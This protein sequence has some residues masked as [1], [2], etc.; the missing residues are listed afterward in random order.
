M[1]ANTWIP[2]TVALQGQ[3]DGNDPQ[4]E[5]PLNATLLAERAAAAGVAVLIIIGFV[6]SYTTVRD[7]AVEVGDFPAW[8]A[9]VVPLSFD[10]GIIVLSLRILLAAGDGRPARVLRALVL[11]LSV[12][13]VVVNGVASD[14][15]AGRLLHA[16]PSAM[17]VICFETV[18]VS[19]QHRALGAE[20]TPPDTRFRTARWLLA[21]RS[22]WTTWRAHVLTDGNAGSSQAAR[23]ATAPASLGES[24]RPEVAQPQRPRRAPRPST[25][26]R[27]PPPRGRADDRL[28]AARDVL[29]RNPDLSA[30]ALA[31]RLTDLGYPVSTRTAQRIRDTARRYLQAASPENPGPTGASGNA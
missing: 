2:P 29:T 16:V 15:L 23:T 13:T 27:T 10:V 31:A 28:T 9:P 30:S 17:F 7:M 6:A 11:L 18:I 14:S 25:T 24:R 4:G 22:T 8:L 21:P 26:A 3:D 1:S 20:P 12:A 5:R 19:A